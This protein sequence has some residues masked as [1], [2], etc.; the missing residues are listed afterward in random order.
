MESLSLI[1][2]GWAGG[3]FSQSQESLRITAKTANLVDLSAAG[4]ALYDLPDSLYIL[5]VTA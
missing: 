3:D 1:S 2:G 5:L 4:E